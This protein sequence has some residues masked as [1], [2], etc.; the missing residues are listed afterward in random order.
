M[1]VEYLL[2][3]FQPSFVLCPSSKA[4]DI[5]F[6]P[7][8]IHQLDEPEAVIGFKVTPGASLT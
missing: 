2:F 3:M 5:V 8:F 6:T 1:F 7:S 4:A